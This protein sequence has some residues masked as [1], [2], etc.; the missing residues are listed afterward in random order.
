MEV[1]QQ[2]RPRRIETDDTRQYLE[3]KSVQ[4]EVGIRRIENL[5]RI[6]D[7]ILTTASIKY[8]QKGLIAYTMK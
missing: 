6:T 1:M 7:V 2:T 4:N 3:L 8:K 5:R